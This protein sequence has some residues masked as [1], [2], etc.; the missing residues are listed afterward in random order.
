MLLNIVRKGQDDDGTGGQPQLRRGR[1][2]A[3]YRPRGAEADPAGA[4]DDD[5]PVLTREQLMD[6]V[7]REPWFGSTKTLDVHMSHLRKKLSRSSVRIAT[8]RHVG[9]RLDP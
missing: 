8:L 4:H 7:W 1:A 5:A 9:Y 3:G 2:P 6:R